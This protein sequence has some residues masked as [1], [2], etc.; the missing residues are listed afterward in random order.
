MARTMGTGSARG[1][2]AASLTVLAG[3][4]AAALGALTGA[5]IASTVGAWVAFGLLPG[6]A[7]VRVLFPEERG[8]VAIARAFFL[9][10]L[11][12]GAAA[13]VLL[14]AGASA[15]S[16]AM[17]LLVAGYAL[18]LV[19]VFYRGSPSP[20]ARRTS[21]DRRLIWWLVALAVLA[22][23]PHLREWVR[24][25]SDA[26]FHAAVVFEIDARGLPP[27]DPYFAGLRLQYMW[28]YHALLAVW[29][30]AAG[31]AAWD[32][33]G[34]LNALWLTS[35]GGAVYALSRRVG[36]PGREAFFAAVFVPLGLDA[37]FTLWIPLKLFRALVGETTGWAELERTF[38][39]RP[40]GIDQ[41]FHFISTLG[42]PPPLLNKYLVMTALGGAISGLVW[43]AEGLVGW[44]RGPS[45]RRFVWTGL[46]LFAVW[47]WNP[48]LGLG[49]TLGCLLAGV[50]LLLRPGSDPRSRVRRSLVLGAA[51]AVL[52]ATLAALPLLRAAAGATSSRFPLGLYP[53]AF[54]P[55]LVPSLAA[56]LFGIP[57]LRRL[58]AT[59]VNRVFLALTA[60]M[61]VA[62]FLVVLPDPNSQ[63]KMPFVFYLMP[64]VAAGW[65]LARVYR[66]LCLRGRG[67][68]ARVLLGA[69][70]IP[71]SAL[72]WTGYLLDPPDPA[73]SPEETSL[74]AWLRD[75]TPRDAVVL[76]SGDRVDILVR[77]PRRQL[78]GRETYARI[79][80]YDPAEMNRRRLVRD[81]FL[82]AAG[83]W[84]ETAWREALADTARVTRALDLLHDLAG[85]VG[86]PVY[87]VWRPE[88]HGGLDAVGT[89]LSRPPFETQWSNPAAAVYRYLPP[90]ERP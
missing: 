18:G 33:A 65:M 63:D 42:S 54:L 30:R 34:S 47:I 90:G 52:V 35:L 5:T 60:G 57:A 67:V 28:L 81:V 37:L 53:R 7:A 2:N 15:D 72:C 46:A 59:P 85:Q 45:A 86:G 50:W 14:F 3:G 6:L 27:D 71:A 38:S 64:A 88:D 20:A 48:A 13:V 83:P 66:A 49:G 84:D 25:R 80:G 32:L 44:V 10:P 79:W 21:T 17:I 55:I 43:V 16:A 36:R 12:S 1:V 23:A 61:M 78:W 89:P 8:A 76:D 70:L 4:L 58:R 11:L 62:A 26:W 77:A 41:V 19:T 74:A 56:L 29:S 68:L 82:G 31:V 9:S 69:I 75:Q 87:V 73:P 22:L 39:L 40:F 24:M 51:A